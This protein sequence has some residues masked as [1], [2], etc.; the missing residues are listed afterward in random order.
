MTSHV[1][2]DGGGENEKIVL[3]LRNV[4]P[5]GVGPGKPMF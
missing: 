3:A 4:H 2:D 1:N 5:I